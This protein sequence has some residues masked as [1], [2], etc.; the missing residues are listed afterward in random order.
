MPALVA[1]CRTCGLHHADPSACPVALVLRDSMHLPL[2]AN[3]LIAGRYRILNLVYRGPMSMVY[4]AVDTSRGEQAIVI[5]ELVFSELPEAERAEAFT[6]FLR[7]AHLLST[8]RHRALP[9]LHTTFSEGDRSYLVMEAVPGPSLE[10]RARAARLPETQ[11]LRWG[12]EICAILHFLHSQREPIIYRDLKPANV[13]E[14]ADTGELVLVDFGVARRLRAGES[15]GPDGAPV[16]G[17]AVGTPGYAAPEQYQGLA[18]PRS[19]IY[20]LGATLHRLLT[21][22]DP[23]V[24]DPFRHPPVRD[25]CPDVS[26]VTAAAVDR[27]LAL[28]PHERFQSAPELRD[29]LRVA[30]PATPD[31]LQAVT[32]PFY[33]WTTVL[34][35]V[36]APLSL[37]SFNLLHQQLALAGFPIWSWPALLAGVYAPSLLYLYPLYGLH[38]R[39]AAIR[40]PNT[41]AAVRRARGLLALRLEFTVPFWAAITLATTGGPVL[42]G[43]DVLTVLLVGACLC[44]CISI[45]RAG[46]AP[47]VWPR[48]LTP[49]T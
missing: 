49:G 46:Q 17:T 21:G 26:A 23:E 32:A 5:K 10:A 37:V 9:A 28:A 22:Y 35:G 30:L 24:E 31:L 48:Q 11:V 25:L 43:I 4:R 41:R 8:L 15:P 6:W 19:D 29:A 1:P 34:P 2:A 45:W 18:D 44:W 39:G 7:E 42:P 40:G 12:I 13:L 27:A 3:A 38:R 47:R 20:A 14:R 36:T 33:F 16:A